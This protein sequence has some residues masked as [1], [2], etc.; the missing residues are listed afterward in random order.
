MFSDAVCVREL[1]P[2]A[3]GLLAL[4]TRAPLIWVTR[5]GVS[6]ERARRVAIAG[7]LFRTEV[8]PEGMVLS[9]TI[10]GP[11]DG[12]KDR[13]LLEGAAKCIRFFGAD[14]SRGLGGCQCSL[15]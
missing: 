4:D 10:D 13:E 12:V 3:S 6:V 2:G 14:S 7:H 11:T 8:A 5:S 15:A 1:S 9:G